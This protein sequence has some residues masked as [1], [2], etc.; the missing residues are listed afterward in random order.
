MAG[1]WVARPAR[2]L[3]AIKVNKGGYKRLVGFEDGLEFLAQVEMFYAGRSKWRISD[4]A[5]R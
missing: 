5:P 4:I 1:C 2:G 3:C